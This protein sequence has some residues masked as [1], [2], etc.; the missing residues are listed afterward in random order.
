MKKLA[1][2]YLGLVFKAWSKG[3][4]VLRCRPMII[5]MT[6][7]ATYTA[8]TAATVDWEGATGGTPG[9]GQNWNAPLNWQGDAIPAAG[10]DITLGAPGTGG[11]VLN[12]NTAQMVNSISADESVILGALGSNLLLTNSTGNVS[13]SSGDLLTIGAAIGGTN[14]INLSGGGALYLTNTLSPFTGN[15]TVDGAGTT[16][17]HRQEGPTVQYNGAGSAQE[18]GRFDQVTLGWSTAARTINLTNGGTYRIINTGNNSEGNYKN[19]SIGSGGG[20]LDLAGGFLVQNLDD[21][22]QLVA[23]T[24]TFTKAGGGRLILTGA[25]ADANPLGG[26]VNIDGGMLSMDRLAG[27][28]TTAGTRF[29]G[30]ASTGT[31]INI[32]NGG[33]LLLNNGTQGRLD[34]PTVNLNNGGILAVQGQDQ[35]VGLNGGGTS[36]NVSGTATL[37]T[38]DLFNAQQERL[39]RIRTDIT[40][41]GTLEV[42]GNTNAGGNPR[43]VIERNMS[44]AFNGTIRIMEN[45]AVEA[46]P[47]FNTT[48]NEGSVIG[49]GDIE[50]AGWAARF[51]VRDAVA[52]TSVLNYNANDIRVTSPQAGT[53]AR[54]ATNR[55]T[56]ASTGHLFQFGTLT[57]GN[58]RLSIEGNNSF[59]SG[60]SGTASIRGNASLL[61]SSDNTPVVFSN[62]AAISEDAAGRSLTILKGGNTTSAARD[63]ISGG[64]I[65]VSTVNVAT[66]T[67]QL[68]GANGAIGTAFGGAAPVINVNGTGLIGNAANLPTAGLLHLDSNTGHVV[69]ANTVFAAAANTNR[70]V[71]SA[72][73][74]LR[75]NA[76]LRVTSPDNGTV[77]ETI[78]TGNILGHGTLDIVKSGTATAPVALTVTNFTLGTNATANLTGGNLGLAGNNSSRIVLG[79]AATGFLGAAYHSIN[80]WVKYSTTMDSGVVLG[81]TPFVAGDYTIGTAENTWAAGQQ[82]KQNG[83]TLPT[84]T[85]NRIADRFN[86]QT[87]VANQT[88]DLAGFKLTADRG[89]IISSTNA[90]GFKDGAAGAAPSG[91]A[92]ITAGSTAAPASLFVHSNATIE[93]HA[94]II[95]NTAGG[96][97]T[98]VKSG[99]GTVILSHQDRA[100]G[101]A[102]VANP[103]TTSTWSSTNTGG[104]VINDGMLNVH[105]GEFLGASPT[106]VTLNGGQLEINHPASNANADTI[107]PGWGHNIVINGNAML[108]MD[109][110]GEVTDAGSGDRTLVKLGS[111]TV[112][113]NSIVG[114]A[115]YSDNDIAFMNGAVINGRATLHVGANGRS[116]TNTAAIISGALTGSGFD[117][118]ALSGG[119]STL[120]LGGTQSDNAANTYSGQVIVYAGPV[121]R[122]NKANGTVAITNGSD[123]EDLVINGGTFAWGPGQHGDLTSTNNVAL[124][125]NTFGNGIVPTSPAAVKAAGQ[126]QISDSAS[127]TLLAGTFGEGDRINNETFNQ[128][129]QKNGIFNVGLGTINVDSATISGGAFNIDRSGAFN[130]GT[131]TLQPGAPDLN[132]TT[133]LPVAGSS[134]VL[135]VG[136]GG[137]SLSGQNIVLGSGSSGN[138]AG[139]G[140]VLNLG[141]DVTATGTDLIGGSYGRKG[142]F[143]QTGNSF[144]ELGSSRIDLQ[145]GNRSFNIGG[146][147][148]FTMTAPLTNGG[149]TK[150]GNGQLNLENYTASTFT[151]AVTVNAGVLSARADNAFGTAAGGVTVNSGGTVKLETGWIYR[152]AFTVTGPGAF[153]PGQSDIREFGAVVADSGTSRLTGAFVLGGDVTVAASN[154]LDPSVAPGAGGGAWRIGRLQLEGTGGVTGA[155]TLTFSGNGDGVIL[156][157]LNTASGGLIKE[158]AGTLTLSAAATY[159]GD[160]IIRAGGVRVSSAAALGATAAG[161][162][163]Q[164]GSLELAGGIALAEPLTVYGMGRSSQSGA[165]VNAAGNNSLSSTLVL[166]GAATLRADAGSLR[167]A[168][169]SGSGSPLTVSGPGTGII[170]GNVTLGTVSGD[171]F[172][173][174]GTGNWAVVG[175]GSFTGGTRIDG[176]N[177]GLSSSGAFFD[178]S[179]PLTMGGG[180]LRILG[181]AQTVNGLNLAAGGGS[182]NGG[183]GL[184]AGAISVTPGAT[185]NFDGSVTTSTGNT[186]GILGAYATMGGADWAVGGGAI[187]AFSGYTSLTHA[188]GAGAAGQHL[189]VTLDANGFANGVHT[190]AIGGET[191]RFADRQG[192]SLDANTVTAGMGGILKAGNS[193]F[194]LGGTGLVSGTSSGSDLTVHVQGGGLYT[195]NPL[196][197]AGTG[198]LIKSGAGDL[199]LFNNASAFTGSVFI[200][201]GSITIAGAA[202]APGYL[203]GSLAGANRLININGGT[204]AVMG[205]WDLNDWD[206]VAAG[207]QSYQL[208]IGSGG[209]TISALYGSTVSINDGSATSTGADQQLR[210]SGDLS[211]AGGGRYSLSGG[212]PQFTNFTGNTT[213]SGGVL[214]LGHSNALG[215][216]QEQLITLN[217]GSAVINSTGF[218][219]GQNGLPNNINAPS[220]GVEFFAA[221]GNRVYGG[222]I[223][224][225]GTNTVY[226]AERDTPN[227]ERQLYFN[228]RVSGTGATLNVVGANNANP[229]YLASGA[230]DLTGT[231]NLGANAV[232]EV[233][234]PGSLGLKAGDVNVNLSGANSRLLLRHWQN[235]DYL[236]DVSVGAHAEINSDRLTGYAGG[237]SQLLSINNLTTSGNSILT[238][239]GGNGYTTRIA[240]T[241]SFKANTPLNSGTAVLFSNGISHSGTSTVL[242]ARGTGSVVLE[243][244]SNHTG[245]TIVQNGFLVL[246][247][248]NGALTNTSGVE[249]RGGELRLDS[250][251]A[252]NTDRLPNAAPIT[253]GG[254]RLRITG[255]ETLGTVT[256]A[257]GTTQVVFNPTSETTATA[258]TLTGFT[259][260]TGSVVQFQTSDVGSIT[261]GST[262]FG[263]A[264]VSSRIL[265]PGQADTSQTIRGL[266][267]NNNIDFIQ[268]DGTTIDNGA[269]LGV[270]DMRNP[271]NS[272]ATFPVNYSDNTAETGWNDSVI[273]RRTNG[274]DATVVTVNLTANRALDAMKIETGGSNRDITINLGAN[275]LR[276]E[277]GGII[278]VSATDH[279]T[280]INGT[281]GTLTAGAGAPATGTAELF[282]GGTDDSSTISAIVANN[283]ASGQNVAVVK[284]GT[285]RWNLNGVNTYTGGTYVTQGTLN[286]TNAGGFG[287]AASTINLSG[288][289][290]LFNVASASSGV[291]LGLPDHTVNVLAN[292]QITL[293]NGALAGADNDV[294]LGSLNVPGPYTLRLFSF[295]SMDASFTGTH[296]FA[297]TPTIDMLQAASGGNKTGFFTL[298]GAITGSGFNVG[299]SGNTDNTTSVLQI[300]GGAGDTAAN[301]YTGK[302][303]LLLGLGSTGAQTD[304]LEVQLNKAAGTTAITGD[305]EINGG[306]VRLAA[307]NQIADTSNVTVNWGQLNTNAL[308]ETVNSITL[309][310]GNVATAPSTGTPA[311]STLNI[312]GD[313]TVSGADDVIGSGGTGFTIGN[314]STVNVGGV[315]RISQLGRIHLTEGASGAFLNLNGGLELT[316]AILHQNSGAGPNTVRLSSDVTTFASA[317]PSNIGNSTDSDTFLELNGVRA[318]DVAD[319]GAGIDLALSTVIRNSTSPANAGGIYKTGAGTMQIQGGG[320]NNTYSGDTTVSQGSL[321]LFKSAG[322]NAVSGNLYIAD[323]NGPASVVVRNSNQIADTAD[324]NIDAQGTL[325][326]QS[327]NTSEGMRNLSSA[328]GGVTILGPSSALTVNI[329]TDTLYAGS[330]L[331][332]GDAA[333]A[334]TKNGTGKW[335]LTGN[336]EYSGDTI[337]NAGILEVDGFLN[338]TEINV[339]NTATLSGIGKVADVIVNNGGTLSPGNSP[340]VLTTRSVTTSAGSTSIFEIGSLTAGNGL[341][342][343][344]QIKSFGTVSLDGTLTVSLV[345]AFQPAYFDEVYLWLNDGTDA[346]T[347]TFTGLPEGAAIPTGGGDWWVISYLGNGDAGSLANDVKLTYVPE[348][349]AALLAA[350]TGLIALA[351]RRRRV[352]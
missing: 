29:A 256:A 201:G 227:Q 182:V 273:L 31:A 260:Q 341:A 98:F 208:N 68:R 104:W 154:I 44:N 253:L 324:V 93:F 326:L 102:Q 178:S 15:I 345:N 34:V 179:S 226:L 62:P 247:G 308:S 65:S 185:V 78:G 265:I 142:I 148:L 238:F 348:P 20:T 49:Q 88:L 303:T 349:S 302:V 112:N 220:G 183:A 5:T 2:S 94:P 11:G 277:G 184:T 114:L 284:T 158:G 323:G 250:S 350:G 77:S 196:I 244:P 298:S 222:D 346:I 119:G 155:G 161:T 236:A 325:D 118:A 218:G 35:I 58:Q 82:I 344:D 231:I 210:G 145:G 313:L 189:N 309:N 23:G 141:G 16:L 138:V 190:V 300:G 52:A 233:R 224:L 288:G 214:L 140:G 90:I 195:S 74:N 293:D 73:L 76:A 127:V 151:G 25:L 123:A 110:N 126:N 221:G 64:A 166:G 61:M 122:A 198:S 54:L 327:F 86:F 150:T 60:F 334:V 105:R 200:N 32:N 216:R 192:L 197:G 37:L 240:G 163:I 180:S 24:N 129:I 206:T 272:T 297:G 301:T 53:V 130:A 36:L 131:L 30:I 305:L 169:I 39:P 168:A 174:T 191:L 266:V 259:R 18:F 187:S 55:D 4:L 274:T 124:T 136:S 67:L 202:A 46:I 75:G 248:A 186:N 83:A 213:V 257:S 339:N 267:G 134:T 66:G 351:R 173:K 38:R 249:L 108:G 8:S 262:S 255:Q 296:A 340:G 103:F 164:G 290:L 352:A 162:V 342:F 70:I 225:S 295:D 237:N 101:A 318:F 120:V 292:S 19:I 10:D 270:R 329:A 146:D 139:S 219:L 289:T 17:I 79:G 311:A 48:A 167:T 268:Y 106:T 133:G 343:H 215:G 149:I 193:I 63:V 229:F 314:N 320:H 97:V 278:D 22:N 84:L 170:N 181:A 137:L 57:M 207:V 235:G 271:G 306:M 316:G 165:V 230:N 113:N 40:G 175:N 285:G 241:A 188:M 319:G 13:V 147:T 116:G 321:V 28:A 232:M 299:S 144:R 159:T 111:L 251:S 307:A 228:G 89:G 96:A 7:A 27:G 269:P 263:Q 41:S 287:S 153:I 335:S 143:V 45:Q 33:T 117:V 56:G 95:D 156:N 71:D 254:G 209:G 211:F 115:A 91:T 1:L 212:V 177:L 336:S 172:I 132:I 14:G 199:R 331:G 333:A 47:R 176:G 280:N 85:A 9:D 234:Q 100:V 276:I 51:D 81:A 43:L 203:G 239:S 80:E 223:A 50:L 252:T 205:D 194:N 330:I 294:S 246:Q 332:G 315:A 338:G 160:T 337:V 72:T 286:T 310:G 275:N 99:T 3:R 291:D 59:H 282:L 87:T 69:G 107:L 281:T 92:G 279:D 242:D 171:A 42:Y 258:L 304:N 204:L 347:G 6:V 261:V 128:F 157:G 243:G 135:G 217:S 125:N 283:T 109:D 21:V 328:T 121:L 245:L 317:H 12:L 152:D 26:V 312:T 322:A 264:R